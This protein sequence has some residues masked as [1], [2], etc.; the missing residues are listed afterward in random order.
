MQSDW[1]AQ[2]L[3]QQSGPLNQAYRLARQ[4]DPAHFA[5]AFGHFVQ[6]DLDPLLAALGHWADACKTALCE[7]AYQSGLTMARHGWLT[8]GHQP[9]TDRMFQQVLPTWLAPYPDAAP[10]LLTQFLN[11]LSHLPDAGQQTRLLDYWERCWPTPDKTPDALVIFSWMSGLPQYRQA[12]IAVLQHH[13]DWLEAL[14]MGNAAAFEH[15]WWQGKTLQWHRDPAQLGASHWLGGDFPGR[16]R[17]LIAPGMTLVQAGQEYWHLHADA[18][19]QVL[20]PTAYRHP[21][22]LPVPD[23]K[24][25]PAELSPLWQE[26][27]MPRQ[28]LERRHDWVVSFHASYRLLVIPKIGDRS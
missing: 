21:L 6:Q 18:F 7:T 25:L 24:Q 4:G 16:P 9:I 26:T 28:C 15:P 19:G 3:T 20:L 12:A 17:L 5:N 11:T 22:L 1:L 14:G 27:E 13:P 10:R 23:C 2:Y 8:P